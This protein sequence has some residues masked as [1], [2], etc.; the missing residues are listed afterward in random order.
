MR[1]MP[2]I[3]LVGCGLAVAA[4]LWPAG[5]ADATN[6][7]LVRIVGPVRL[8]SDLGPALDREIGKAR[9]IIEDFRKG[10][11]DCA[12]WAVDRLPARR[13]DMEKWVAAC[14]QA[15]PGKL[16][17]AVDQKMEKGTLSPGEDDMRSFL[18][19]LLGKQTNSAVSG[20]SGHVHAV[21]VNHA[22]LQ[23]EICRE[24]ADE[25][26]AAV[27]RTAELVSELSPSMPSWLLLE[28]NP[29]SAASLERW[30]AAIGPLVSG[31]YLHWQ[32]GLNITRDD[33]FLKATS[34]LLREK[35]PI[36][37]ADFLY[38]SPRVRPAIEKDLKDQY[39]ER[40]RKYEGWVRQN[41]YAGYSRSVGDAIPGAVS[42][43][44]SL[45]P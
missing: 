37:R 1:R 32:H 11:F 28:D 35:K 18:R 23:N 5:A 9:G 15:F 22:R 38:T 29:A 44:L 42:V 40:M 6:V 8:S 24:N 7:P 10:G 26:I 17:V 34:G 3:L 16:V 19:C 43:N 20:E 41:G 36:I 33:A 13:E 4:P 30:A 12:L 14:L 27:R 39:V 45:L 31:Y 21:L 2:A 25:A